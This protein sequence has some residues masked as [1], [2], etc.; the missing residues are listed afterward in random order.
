[1]IAD[2]IAACPR[3][4]ILATSRAALRVRAEQQFRVPPLAAP[5]AGSPVAGIGCYPA[6]QLF[7][8]RA[9]ALRSDLPADYTDNAQ[10]AAAIADICRRL[11]GLPLAIELAAA[12][13]DLPTPADLARRLAADPDALG[14]GPQDLPS[15]SARCAPRSTGVIRCCP[16]PRACCS[17]GLPSSQAAARSMP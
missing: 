16:R 6:V 7:V 13:T 11:D 17:P 9:A 2:L 4:Q 1:L 15:S 8:S 3:V 12:R 5:P 10:T 14:E